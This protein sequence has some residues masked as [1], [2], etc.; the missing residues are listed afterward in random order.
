ME[1][2]STRDFE[3]LA[4][5]EREGLVRFAWGM[6]SDAHEAEDMAQEALTRLLPV[7]GRAENPRAYLY[8]TITNL[9]LQRLQRRARSAPVSSQPQDDGEDPALRQESREAVRRALD[10]LTENERAAVLLREVEHLSYA[11][12]AETLN[13]TVSQ[14]T[15]W[16]S[17][18]KS[19]LRRKLLPYIEKGEMP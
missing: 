11:K 6:L 17:R 3:R 19:E 1:N 8:K 16:I 9:C 18:G 2:T 5:A 14:V 15:N 4:V 13:A 10:S 7:Y 12:I